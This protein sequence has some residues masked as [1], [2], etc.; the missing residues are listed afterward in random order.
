MRLCTA[1]RGKAS[2]FRGAERHLWEARHP[3]RRESKWIQRCRAA[4]VG[5]PV[6]RKEE[7]EVVSEV[8]R[9]VKTGRGT[10][11]RR[12]TSYFRGEPPRQD[13]ERHPGK[14]EN[15]LFQR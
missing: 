14:K 4:P 8:S 15:K 12:K 2:S 10:P 9:R 5:D 7:K 13:R 3:G 1:E 6:P 11:E